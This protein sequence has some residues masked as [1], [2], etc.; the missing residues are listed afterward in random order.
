M[1]GIQSKRVRR[2]SGAVAFQYP[3][4]SQQILASFRIE[5]FGRGLTGKFQV[6]AFQTTLIIW[7]FSV[8]QPKEFLVSKKRLFSFR[9]CCPNS[10]F[11]QNHSRYRRKLL[12]FTRKDQRK[13]NIFGRFFEDS[14][15]AFRCLTPH[16]VLSQCS[17]P[18]TFWQTTEL[19]VSE[20][21]S[22]LRA[23]VSG[24]RFES[25]AGFSCGLCRVFGTEQ[26]KNGTRS[27]LLIFQQK[28]SN[29]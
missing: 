24:L 14:S 17:L 3:V 6:G 21:L 8:E 7:R 22:T 1:T 20:V 26:L 23:G 4:V 2:E 29:S 15:T 10:G 9:S 5:P 25:L 28:C 16:E 18:S 27:A 11:R 12:N 13:S 19:P